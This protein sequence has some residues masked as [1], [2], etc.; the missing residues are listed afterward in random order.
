MKFDPAILK[1]MDTANKKYG[2]GTV[3]AASDITEGATPRITTGSLG[4]DLILGGGWPG[5]KVTEIV[6]QFSSGKTALAL[7][8]IAANQ[9]INPDFR[10]VWVAAEEWVEDF[11]LLCGVD[12]DRVLVVES[13]IM[14]EVFEIILQLCE[15]K[16][17]DLVVLDSQPMLIPK[18]EDEK[19][20]MGVTMASGAK[21]TNKF[22][23][24]VGKAIRRSLVEHERPVTLLVINQ[25]RASM[26]GMYGNPI[27]TP[28]GQGKD[29]AYSTKVEVKRMGWYKMG[30]G[31]KEVKIG[32]EMKIRTTKNKTAP[33]QQ[34]TKLDFYFRDGGPVPAGD[35]DFAPEI[36]ALALLTGVITRAGATYTFGTRTW[37]SKVKGEKGVDLILRDIYAEPDLREE[38]DQAVRANPTL[39][40]AEEDEDDG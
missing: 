2:R 13:N 32:Q 25:F 28:G 17:V 22:Y 39:L 21:I 9:A 31:E 18:D 35:Y 20:M 11:A 26:A 6:G 30:S 27:T 29:Y 5:N 38:I 24:K 16:K 37:R 40:T 34:V 8:T 36:L 23:R 15:T 7:K 19:D 33:P 4:L 10:T 12:L 3:V 14:E 1:V